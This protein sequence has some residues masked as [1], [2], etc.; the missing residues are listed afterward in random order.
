VTEDANSNFGCYFG[1]LVLEPLPD[2]RLMRLVEPFGFLDTE[3]KRWPVPSGAK[4]DG[5][6]IPQPLWSLIGGPFEG[7]YRDASVVHDYYCDVRT[8]PWRAVHRV[9]YNA[10]RASGVSEPRAKLM[11]AAVRFAGPRWTDTAVENARLAALAEDHLLA[12]VISYGRSP[13]SLGVLGATSVEGE[14]AAEVTRRENTGYGGLIYER[15]W[16]KGHETTLRLDRLEELIESENP[17]L[18]EID[19][20][21]DS[22]VAALEPPPRDSNERVRTLRSDK[23]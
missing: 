12:D 17:S 1:R 7:K 8:E 14:S 23:S 2:G 18:A 9:F 4:V 10:M 11:Y 16:P 5:A 19:F 6:S 15:Q 22:A 21:I 13:F 20:S 3:Q